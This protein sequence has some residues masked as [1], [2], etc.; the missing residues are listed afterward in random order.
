M[1]VLISSESSRAIKDLMRYVSRVKPV[2]QA[3]L[4]DCPGPRTVFS[5]VL[6]RR[7]EELIAGQPGK[8][9]GLSF[10]GVD[11]LTVEG[12]VS[13][14]NLKQRIKFDTCRWNMER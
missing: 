13:N 1:R 10:N 7:W 11:N 9:R 5:V 12:N 2:S 4:T 14:R 6:V 8:Y 3:S